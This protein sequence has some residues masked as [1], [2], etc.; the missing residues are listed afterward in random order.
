[1][2]ALLEV[3]LPILLPALI[4]L[5]S[6]R[7]ERRRARA[8]ADHTGAPLW[9][10]APWLALAAAGVALAAAVL[11]VVVLTGGEPVGG[12]YV[13]A[14]MDNGRLVPGMVTHPAK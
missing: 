10:R 6:V 8:E 2:R 11:S 5:A 1:M 13:P 3:A 12:V 4:Y 9:A 14:H 7:I